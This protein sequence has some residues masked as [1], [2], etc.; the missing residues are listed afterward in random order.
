MVRREQVMVVLILMLTIFFRVSPVMGITKSD[1]R[2]LR[3][4]NQITRCVHESRGRNSEA[5]DGRQ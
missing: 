2:A 5:A 4:P 1:E 3:K